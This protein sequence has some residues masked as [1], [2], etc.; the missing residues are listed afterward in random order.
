MS[1][2]TGVDEATSV[3]VNDREPNKEMV[4]ALTS[5]GA[6]L[7]PGAMPRIGRTNE[8]GEKA[9]VEALTSE[10]ATKAKKSKGQ[11]GREGQQRDRGDASKDPQGGSTGTERRCA[12][13]SN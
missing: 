3:R 11:K 8:A 9:V 13:V 1:R 7:G 12:E 4:L 6:P 5:E 2:K 10:A